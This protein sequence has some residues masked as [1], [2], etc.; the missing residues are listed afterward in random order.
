MGTLP[1]ESYCAAYAARKR[2]LLERLA[3][4]ARTVRTS[5]C[6][7]ERRQTERDA[8]TKYDALS[9]S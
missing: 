1:I 7:D 4:R 6:T 9:N 2:V 3:A 8:M 5:R